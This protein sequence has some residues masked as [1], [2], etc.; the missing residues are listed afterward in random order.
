MAL[1]FTRKITQLNRVDVGDLKNIITGIEWRITVTDGERELTRSGEFGP[2]RGPDP[3]NFTPKASLTEAEVLA[4]AGEE[5]WQRQESLLA[6]KF[7]AT[8]E[9]EALPWE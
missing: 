9:P 2:F 5:Y 6:T 1:T 7:N 4:W 8:K 3:K